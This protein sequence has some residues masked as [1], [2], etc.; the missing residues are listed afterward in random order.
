MNWYFY[1]V[2]LPLIGLWILALVGIAMGQIHLS[3]L[4][5]FISWFFLGPVGIGV[6]FH[7]LFSHRQ[8][9]TGY[10]LEMTI[11]ALGTLVAYTPILFWVSNHQ[12]HHKRSDKEEDPSSPK[13]HGFWESFLWYRLRQS[14]LT[15]V[16][17]KNYC[18]RQVLLDPKLRWLSKNFVKIV[19]SVILILMVIDRN[20]L[21]SLY[22][23]PILI[24]HLRINLVSSVSHIKIPFSYRNYATS[25][26]SYNNFIFGYL[27]MGF[28]WHNNHHQDERKLSLNDKWWELD[29]EGA[30]A[31]LISKPK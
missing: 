26:S 31:K 13:W 4:T 8:F 7:R 5:I 2:F 20:L 1:K 16:D 12:Y 28:A 17:L 19:W 24:E 30:L 29:I 10:F 3:W 15:K 11:A 23:I 6:G 14:A 18:S 27:S 21:V 22:L 9:K 25:D